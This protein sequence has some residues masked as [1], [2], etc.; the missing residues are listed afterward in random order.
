MLRSHHAER[1]LSMELRI[2]S[3]FR[4]QAVRA[5][6]FGLPAAS[7]RCVEVPDDWVIPGCHQSSHAKCGTHPG[8][9]TPYCTASSHG[10]TVAVEG[11]YSD[12][13]RLS[14]GGPVCPTP[15]GGPGVL[16]RSARPR[17]VRCAAGCPSP[18]RQDSPAESAAS[19]CPGRRVPA[20]ATLC[21]PR[22]WSVR[23]RRWQC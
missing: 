8:S 13:R 10:A 20:V 4:M 1:C 6:F 21:E 12:Q 16:E 5:S 2:T 22:C 11:S 3:S 7:N 15:A 19:Q 17:R 23:R 18:S 14:V 9:S